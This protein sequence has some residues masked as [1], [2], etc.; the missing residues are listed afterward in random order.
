MLHVFCLRKVHKLIYCLGNAFS[1]IFSA[2]EN[3]LYIV[4]AVV[5]VFETE[6]YSTHMYMTYDTQFFFFSCI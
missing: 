2:L 4:V 3:V 5:F 6:I 1:V